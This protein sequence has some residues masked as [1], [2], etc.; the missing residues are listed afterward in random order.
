M[1]RP[2]DRI[3]VLWILAFI[4]VGGAIAA[5]IL[6]VMYAREDTAHADPVCDPHVQQCYWYPPE[7]GQPGYVS[8]DPGPHGAPQAPPPPAPPIHFC[9]HGPFI[10]GCNY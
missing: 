5:L 6:I 1:K 8:A 3:R 9:W 10:S 2:W 4:A 7:N